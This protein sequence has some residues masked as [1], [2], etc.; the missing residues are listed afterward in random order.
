[1][2]SAGLWCSSE[3]TPSIFRDPR[4]SDPTAFRGLVWSSLDGKAWERAE[5]QIMAEVEP[6]AV[7]WGN[8][9][10]ML[11]GQRGESVVSFVSKDGARWSDLGVIDSAGDPQARVP[12]LS[13]NAVTWT[14]SEWL[15][16]GTRQG[17]EWVAYTSP[18]GKMWTAADM[19]V[20]PGGITAF[21]GGN[22]GLVA[23]G[24]S[25]TESER[26][27]GGEPVALI[28]HLGGGGG[29]EVTVEAEPL[30]ESA[31]FTHVTAPDQRLYAVGRDLSGD[32]DGLW[33]STD[34]RIW[35]EWRPEARCLKMGSSK[36]CGGTGASTHSLRKCG[37]R[38]MALTGLQRL[39]PQER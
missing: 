17:N 26:K 36:S 1:M 18:T 28:A 24:N 11:I 32:R 33:M 25:E 39:T 12:V 38:Q 20:L 19:P 30:A 15:V 8:D 16:G 7:S 31:G 14:G 6:T 13:I 3:Q 29:W 22:S 2:R 4:I 35:R 5:D 37:P 10:F 21:A 23:V 27:I 9:Q 34:G